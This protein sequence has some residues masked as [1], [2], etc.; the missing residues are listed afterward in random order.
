[1]EMEE[2]LCSNMDHENEDRNTDA[3]QIIPFYSVASSISVELTPQTSKCEPVMTEVASKSSCLVSFAAGTLGSPI[4]K[5]PCPT[6]KEIHRQE[7]PFFPQ[8]RV[9]FLLQS[10]M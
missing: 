8:T 10:L 7:L 5:G 4:I 3:R 9:P 6:V 2:S 1:M